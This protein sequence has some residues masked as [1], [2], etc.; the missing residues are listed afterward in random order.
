MRFLN[1]KQP[2]RIS[3]HLLLCIN[4]M[5][6][7]DFSNKRDHQPTWKTE[8]E[9]KAVKWSKRRQ[10]L[11]ITN[12]E[13]QWLKMIFIPKIMLKWII[14][15]FNIKLHNLKMWQKDKSIC[16][17]MKIRKMLQSLNFNHCKRNKRVDLKE[18]QSH[19]LILRLFTVTLLISEINS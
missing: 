1:P 6:K 15:W 17:S 19:L 13:V 12:I 10:L 18:W 7:L 4:K 5:K 2:W 3:L 8:A 9:N 11:I 14:W 16:W